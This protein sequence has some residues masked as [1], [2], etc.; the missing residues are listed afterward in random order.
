MEELMDL[1]VTGESSSEVSDKIKEILYAKAAE[2]VENLKPNASAG[3]FDDEEVEDI[4]DT[5]D[6]ETEEDE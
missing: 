3:L 5:I 1:M 2:R 6:T 4:E